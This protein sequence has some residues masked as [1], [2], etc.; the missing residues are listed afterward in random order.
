MIF[1][2]AAPGVGVSGV[3]TPPAV[4]SDTD[5]SDAPVIEGDTVAPARMKVAT[6]KPNGLPG[7]ISPFAPLSLNPDQ[8]ME[9][10]CAQIRKLANDTSRLLEGFVVVESDL[11]LD[12]VAVYT[13]GHEGKLQTFEMERV[14]ER[15]Q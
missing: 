13:A 8:A 1:A 6:T 15:K 12:D 11:S 14:P 3:G 7:N 9:V 10:D 5:E 2:A 4:N